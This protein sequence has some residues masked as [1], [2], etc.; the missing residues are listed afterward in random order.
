MVN[1]NVEGAA[2]NRNTISKMFLVGDETHLLMIDDDTVPPFDLDLQKLVDYDKDVLVLPYP[3]NMNN[4]EGNHY[5]WSIFSEP[6]TFAKRGKGL[7]K[8]Y[9]AGTG[10]I[11]IKREVIEALDIPLAQTRGADDR[12]IKAEDYSF[13]ERAGKEGFEIWT[14]WDVTCG[15]YKNINMEELV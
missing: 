10:F 11:L 15:H 14:D 12:I 8:I 9:A 5:V 4:P 2:Y 7:E 3:L 6:K 1:K 13:C